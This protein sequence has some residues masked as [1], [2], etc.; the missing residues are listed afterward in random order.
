MKL[1][2]RLT[3]IVFIVTTL[4]SAAIGGFAISQYQSNQIARLD[5]SLNDQILKL[6]S[7]T[8]DP[9]S[10]VQY[11]AQTSAIQFSATYIPSTNELDV[12][13]VQGEELAKVPT[14][15]QLLKSQSKAISVSPMLRIRT[16]KLAGGEHLVLAESAKAIT[17]GTRTLLR[18]LFFF[19][20]II[21]LLVVI[22]AFY[23]IR[24][25]RRVN[26]A[27]EILRHQRATMQR[28][29]GDA[30]HELR[31]P[32]TVIKGY[33]ELMRKTPDLSATEIGTYFQRVN[34]EIRRMEELIRDLLLLAELG[35]EREID[36]Q[37]VNVSN[38]L[39]DQ[40]QDLAALQANR[41]I[42]FELEDDLFVVGDETLMVRLFSNIFANIRRHTPSDAFVS[43][44]ASQAAK[45]TSIII[46]DAG[47]GLATDSKIDAIQVFER[48]DRSRSRETGG[49]GLGISIMKAVMAKHQGK[50][51]FSRATVGGLKISLEFPA[52]PNNS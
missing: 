6:R 1:V 7:S 41:K 26:A 49:S 24:R 3:F 4:V 27:N 39:R 12:I 20:L 34:L 32:L 36:F 10:V 38:L 48:F 47:P 40:V 37:P 22:V 19:I 2:R 29:L 33:V 5:S 15:A 50:I 18:T 31:T 42:D 11:L 51:E 28:F 9:L 8:E 16:F 23:F 43:V 14:A 13:T 52:H 21:D 35:E 44:K 45:S 46:E 25:D 30:S 17:E